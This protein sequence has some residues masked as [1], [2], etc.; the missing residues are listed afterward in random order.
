VLGLNWNQLTILI[1]NALRNSES[2]SVH[3]QD[4]ADYLIQ[5]GNIQVEHRKAR[6]VVNT[7]ERDRLKNM[8]KKG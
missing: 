1:L 8:A 7:C 4:I 2:K 6:S 3:I 5:H